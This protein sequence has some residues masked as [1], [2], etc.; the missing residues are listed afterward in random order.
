[1]GETKGVGSWAPAEIFVGG[2][3]RQAKK[4]PPHKDKEGPHMVKKAPPHPTMRKTW[5]KGPHRKK[6]AE[7]LFSMGGGGGGGGGGGA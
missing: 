5:Q 6:V 4:G 1:M 2:R 7:R 3:G